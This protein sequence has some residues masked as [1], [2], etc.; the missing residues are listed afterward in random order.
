MAQI[1]PKFID[2]KTTSSAE[3]PLYE[4]F[5]HKLDD[6]P[7]ADEKWVV[8]HQVR[9]IGKDDLGRPRDGEADFVVAHIGRFGG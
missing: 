5:A 1:S 4:A 9:W 7:E 3:C 6:A 2:P 8:F